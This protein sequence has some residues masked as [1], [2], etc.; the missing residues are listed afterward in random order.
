VRM[1]VG[2]PPSSEDGRSRSAR[3]VE[4]DA[5]RSAARCGRR[6]IRLSQRV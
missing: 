6:A 2:E 5:L 4:L 3:R 1:V